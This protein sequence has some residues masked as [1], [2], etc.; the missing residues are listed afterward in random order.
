[1]VNI[2]TTYKKLFTSESPQITKDLTYN[3]IFANI[4]YG[5]FDIN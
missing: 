3:I 2:I 4:I 1:M 5:Y